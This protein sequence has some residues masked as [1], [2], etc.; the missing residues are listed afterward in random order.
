MDTPSWPT[1]SLPPL[2]AMVLQDPSHVDLLAGSGDVGAAGSARWPLV[3]TGPAQATLDTLRHAAQIL[4]CAVPETLCIQAGQ[5]FYHNGR[6][7]EVRLRGTCPDPRPGELFCLETS[8]STPTPPCLQPDSDTTLQRDPAEAGRSHLS[9]LV[10]TDEAAPQGFMMI[11]TWAFLDA[12]HDGISRE[13]LPATL[14]KQPPIPPAFPDQRGTI[15]ANP[16]I[17]AGMAALWKGGAKARHL[18][19]GW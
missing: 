17:A 12:V 14:P 13:P 2:V 1:T 5:L 11:C 16:L 19:G 9:A 10:V 4:G 7:E 6:L 3:P 8:W 18:Q 15:P